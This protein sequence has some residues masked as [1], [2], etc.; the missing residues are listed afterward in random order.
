MHPVRSV[1][2]VWILARIRPQGLQAARWGR[3]AGEVRCFVDAARAVV[4]SD[5]RVGAERAG[6]VNFARGAVGGDDARGRLPL[7][8]PPLENADLVEGVGTFSTVAMSHAGH[9]EQTNPSLTGNGSCA[10][11]EHRIIKFNSGAWRHLL[12]GPA[13]VDK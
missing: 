11:L 12:I 13:V 7:L 6:T 5:L 4:S 3:A 8:D 9:H 10:V 1:C 2:R